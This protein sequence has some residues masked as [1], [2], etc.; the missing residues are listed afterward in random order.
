MPWWSGG[1]RALD[2]LFG[3]ESEE[4]LDLIDLGCRGG[5]EVGVP[6]RPSGEPVT[7]QPELLCSV[8]RHALAD[9]I[10]GL[11]VQRGEQRGGAMSFV[12]VRASLDL[13]GPHWQQRPRAIQ[14]LDL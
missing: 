12:I 11:H 9:D 5:C 6:A 4:A 7:D 2:L 14:R 1:H 10:S 8:P 3:E 13:P